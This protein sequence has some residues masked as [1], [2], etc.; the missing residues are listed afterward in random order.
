[1]IYLSLVYE[2]DLSE[3][4][5]TKLLGHFKGKFAIHN[6]W[7]GYGFGYLRKKVFAFN[8]AST[9]SPYFMLTDLDNYPCPPELINDWI[10]VPLHPNFIFRVAVKEVEAWLLADIEGLSGFF[11]ISASNFPSRPEEVTDPKQTLINLAKKSRIRRIRE[12]I[13]PVGSN[14]RIGPNYNGCLSGFVLNLW[15]VFDAMKLSRSLE[16][17]YRRLESF[18]E[19]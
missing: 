18:N 2:D 6:T 9:T 15:N 17:A 4:V 12:E 5:M 1:M 19:V 10:N 13:V 3:I 8:Q 16:K 11:R 7:P 14:A